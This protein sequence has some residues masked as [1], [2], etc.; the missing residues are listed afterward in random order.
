MAKTFVKTWQEH[1]SREEFCRK[2]GFD[3]SDANDLQNAYV[4]VGGVE[5]SFVQLVDKGSLQWQERR[6]NRSIMESLD[7]P[8]EWGSKLVRFFIF[9]DD[10]EVRF[11][12]SNY[13]EEDKPWRPQADPRVSSGGSSWWTSVTSRWRNRHR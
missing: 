7:L 1:F 11:V 12:D 10:V 6:T 13:V 3:V 9:G 4:Q 2:L 5:F 8:R